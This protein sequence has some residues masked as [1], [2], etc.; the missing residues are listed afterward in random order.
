MDSL[1]YLGGLVVVVLL[2]STVVPVF[3]MASEESSDPSI[4]PF[5]EFY[6]PDEK[7]ERPIHGDIYA[8]TF[9]YTYDMEYEVVPENLVMFLEGAC[10]SWHRY[11]ISVNRPDDREIKIIDN[12]IDRDDHIMG[13]HS[14]RHSMKTRE[15][16]YDT[17]S[18][19]LRR[20]EEDWSDPGV[21]N[22]A[23]PTEVLFGDIDEDVL[24]DPEPLKGEYEIIVGIDGEDIEMNFGEDETRLSILS[25]PASEPR[26]LEAEYEDGEVG[27]E[28]D[29]PEDEGGSEIMQYNVYRAT[30][31]YNYDYIGNVSGD[32]TEFVDEFGQE[33]LYLGGIEHREV[34]K[35]DVL[36]Y[37]VVAINYDDYYYLVDS[38]RRRDILP[39]YRE[40]STSLEEI[41]HIPYKETERCDMSYKWIMNYSSISEDD[42]A[43]RVGMDSVNIEKMEG[44][45]VFL[46]DI[47]RSGEEN[48]KIVFE[49]EG[50]FYSKGEVDMVLEDDNSTSDLNMNM[51]KGWFDFSG[52]IWAEEVS[53]VGYEGL[54]IVKQTIHSEGQIDFDLN[55][56]F[57]FIFEE[58][59]TNWQVSESLDISWEIDL[60]LDYEGNNSWIM[61][62]E[63]ATSRVPFGDEFEYSGSIDAE[64]SLIQRS[65]HLEDEKET[66][67]EVSEE[68][69]GT[70]NILSGILAHGRAESFSPLVGAGNIGYYMAVER[71]LNTSMGN[72]D[73]DRSPF[74]LGFS[75]NCQRD[76][77]S[78]E[79]LYG[80]QYM[81]PMALPGMGSFLGTELKR[82]S[83]TSFSRVLEI[84]V[85]Q[86]VRAEMERREEEPEE[87]WDAWKENKT[88]EILGSVILGNPWGIQQYNGIER[89]DHFVYGG[90]V[91][92]PLGYFCSE[93]LDEDDLANY[94]EDPEQF[95][96]NQI[97]EE[98][99]EEIP[100]FNSLVLL[101]GVVFAV[102]VYSKIKN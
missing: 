97:V 29:E 71:S 55:N 39:H 47:S 82:A 64:G 13:R 42:F 41:V 56:S 20:E 10:T 92:E 31:L 50:G 34:R 72:L 21:G 17:M 22:M 6:E 2:V 70:H 58:N 19:I 15:N 7:T 102:A 68:I 11:R 87:G 49:Y 12:E 67:G 14:I 46:Y 86:R 62:R 1:D 80:Y 66:E 4:A 35:G 57:E 5:E 40:R 32:Q 78:T 27:L 79:D 16:I 65:D 43:D 95:F 61:S 74:R 26:N 38:N 84:R 63:N 45:D 23:N 75:T 91:I 94:H 93:P 24:V 9:N 81:D 8:H 76:E 101:I 3:S 25:K 88:D 52:E 36:Y 73:M 100:G 33:T 89:W 51:A 28:W 54:S 98:E 30:S 48:G 44:G 53:G 90:H 77:F 83:L 18:F 69:S 37:R 59:K 96:E 99:E 85:Q 60:T